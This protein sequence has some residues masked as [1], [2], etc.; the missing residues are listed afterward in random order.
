MQISIAI[1]QMNAQ[2]G[3]LRGNSDKILDYLQQ[4]ETAKA[5][6]LVL[7]EACLCGYPIGDIANR[8]H[9]IQQNASA[10]DEIVKAT[11]GRNSAL[12]FGSLGEVPPSD[13]KY[14][15]PQNPMP[16]NSLILIENGAIIGSV[17]KHLLPNEDVFH[18]KRHFSPAPLSQPINFRGIK[19]GIMV[20]YDLWYPNPTAHLSQAGA[21][22]L[23]S[24]NCS[25]WHGETETIPSK[26]QQ[27]LSH[28][29]DRVKESGLPL[30]FVHA[31]GGQDDLL[32]DGQSFALN[33]D[34]KIS[35]QAPAFDE[36]LFLCHWQKTEKFS[37]KYYC[38]DSILAPER[39][40]LSLLY[41]GITTALGDYLRK[42][43]FSQVLL[44][45]SGGIDSALTAAIAVDALGSENVLGILM[46]STYTSP[47]SISDAQ[48]LANNLGIEH[49]TISIED[50]RQ[51]LTQNLNDFPDPTGIAGENIQ[52]RLRGNI[53]MFIANASGKMLLATGNKS[54]VAMGYSTLY[55]DTCGGFAPIKDVYKTDV[56]RLSDWRN[57]NYESY[58]RTPNIKNLIPQNIL[59]KAPT[60]EL[61][62]NQKDEDSL[63]PY[64]K[65]DAML[66]FLIENNGK[67]E[68][69]PNAAFTKDELNHTWQIVTRNE[70]KRQQG[71]IGPQLTPKAFGSG[72][73]YPLAHKYLN[74]Y[75]NKENQ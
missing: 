61:R 67:G 24:A 29:K 31:S 71:A 28:A 74:E 73:R 4:A 63:P 72:W 18:E 40:H 34:G 55:G 16:Y 66:K 39:S 42:T 75:P 54:E 57:Q 23:I 58:M 45:L 38:N 22:I 11:K 27:R 33:P 19:L 70:Y 43:G 5:D 68:P 46:P 21:D 47:E 44:G 12:L 51:Q 20:C 53:L 62:H 50:M 41:Q 1:A 35:M 69:P 48:E 2:S 8:P 15:A 60:A 14:P 59:T 3:D 32:F 26:Q 49:Q 6:L 13:E 56:F 65:L 30:L 10:I 17:S 25:P 64:E 36:G 9:F 7:P 37:N 52:A